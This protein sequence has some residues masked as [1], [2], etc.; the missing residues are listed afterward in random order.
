MISKI[1]N[2]T[3]SKSNKT[4]SRTSKICL[5]VYFVLSLLLVSVSCYADG[6]NAEWDRQVKKQI[7]LSRKKYES[8]PQNIDERYIDLINAYDQGGL[9]A[10][11]Q[12]AKSHMLK[13]IDKNVGANLTIDFE[14]DFQSVSSDLAKSGVVLLHPP[15]APRGVI[16]II[17]R[18]PLAN[19]CGI[20]R[21]FQKQLHKLNCCVYIENV[22]RTDFTEPELRALQDIYETYRPKLGECGSVSLTGTLEGIAYFMQSG[23][24]INARSFAK[25]AKEPITDDTLTVKIRFAPK[26]EKEE[27][28]FFSILSEQNV[29]MISNERTYVQPISVQLPIEK[30]IS[31]ASKNY[32]K[33]ISGPRPTGHTWD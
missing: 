15:N 3:F 31:L 21:Q 30:I 8:Y 9:D 14:G 4:I 32:I 20:S 23:G 1:T 13:L 22:A 12:Y 26:D 11:A 16:T 6:G 24:K 5:L 28:A 10:A 18:V 29:E 27:G 7:E 2:Y 25:L 17:G 19:L 33:Q